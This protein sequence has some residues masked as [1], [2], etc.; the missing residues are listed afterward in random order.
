MSMYINDGQ[1]QFERRTTEMETLLK[2]NGNLQFESHICISVAELQLIQIIWTWI[3]CLH[4]ASI[5]QIRG[6]LHNHI[7][8]QKSL[9]SS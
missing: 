9:F 3:K 8:S 2:Y 7:H 6:T 4:N 5:A 1:L